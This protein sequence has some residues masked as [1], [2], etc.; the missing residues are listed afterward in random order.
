MRL[1]TF[2]NTRILILLGILIFTAAI[3][4]HQLVYTRSWT[5]PLEV[6]ILPMNGDRYLSTNKYIESLSDKNFSRIETWFEREAEKY[7]L[8]L[9][10]PVNVR[11]GPQ[12]RSNPPVYPDN[13]HVL[14]VLWWGLRFRWWVFRNTP[15]IDSDLTLVRIFVRYYTG[16]DNKGLQHSLGMQKGLLG[17]V[18]AYA[19]HTQTAQNN[20]VIAHELLHT[21]G[22][23]D[24]YEMNGSPIYPFGYA[25]PNR[26][27][28]FPQRE[29][30]IMSGRIP[31]SHY[32]SYMAESLKSVVINRYTA[33]EINWLE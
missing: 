17:L 12:V 29:A 8:A 2:K 15:D 9:S 21:V 32:R 28:M 16:D 7:G 30:E 6:V 31:I 24:K 25:H 4:L 23:I 27:P 22:A 11:L 18:H 3:S 10:H 33:A 1:I 20:I 5:K 14:N 13:A 19:L 26:T